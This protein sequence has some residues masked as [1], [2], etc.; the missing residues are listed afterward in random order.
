MELKECYLNASCVQCEMYLED[1]LCS[2]NFHFP[3]DP[4]NSDFDDQDSNYEKADDIL[5][6]F[7]GSEIELLRIM[8]VKIDENRKG[9]NLWKQEYFCYVT[10][11]RRSPINRILKN[12]CFR[13]SFFHTPRS[14]TSNARWT[15]LDLYYIYQ[16]YR[17]KIFLCDPKNCLKTHTEGLFPRESSDCFQ[18]YPS[19]IIYNSC[20]KVPNHA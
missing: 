16:N 7:D 11:Q 9:K 14:Q 5:D 3:Y 1:C 18:R 17:K 2:G 12:T 4:F 19:K 8:K 20:I 10:T 15:D 13:S 6:N